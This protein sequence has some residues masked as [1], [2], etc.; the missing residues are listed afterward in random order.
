[1]AFICNPVGLRQIRLGSNHPPTDVASRPPWLTP[2][3]SVGVPRRSVLKLL[4]LAISVAALPTGAEAFSLKDVEKRKTVDLIKLGKSKAT[5][6]KKKVQEW[7]PC[8][9]D[10][11][12]LVLRFIPI[13]LE[14]ARKASA[15]LPTLFDGQPDTIKIDELSTQ[16]SAL[17]GH[18]LELTQEANSRNTKGIVRELDE[19]VET[20]D[21]ILDIAK[22]NGTI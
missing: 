7:G 10:D 14:P 8:T 15:K 3:C 1:M 4:G 21:V 16:A 20:S 9:D 18:L 5:D 2:T 6:L 11:R 19:F 22:A 17:F 12:L 13:W